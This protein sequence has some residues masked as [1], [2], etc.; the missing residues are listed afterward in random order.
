[1]RPRLG[2]IKFKDL[3]NMTIREIDTLTKLMTTYKKNGQFRGVLALT[4]N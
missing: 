2:L 1:M 4:F 3:G